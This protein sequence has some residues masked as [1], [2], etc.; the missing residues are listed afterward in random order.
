MTCYEV[1]TIGSYNIAKA[2]MQVWIDMITISTD[3]VFD[4]EKQGGYLPEDICNPIWAYGMSKYLWEKMT[5]AEHPDAIIIRTSW[6]YGGEIY[7]SDKGVYKNFVNTMLR[8]SEN[9]DELTV[10][11]DQYGIPTSCMSLSL[12]I[13]QVI[14]SRELYRWKILH[15]SNSCHRDGITWADFARKI[16]EFTEKS[17]HVN[18]CTTSEYP[19]KAKRPAS[20]VLT[21]TS[22]ILLEHWEDVLKK[23]LLGN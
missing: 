21:N 10:V 11:S 12:A 14:Q 20:S 19:T 16:F 2:T 13:S 8:L 1:N 22:D 23:Y 15:F 7:W 17:V 3:Y 4:G 6:L 9:R 18:N 5:L